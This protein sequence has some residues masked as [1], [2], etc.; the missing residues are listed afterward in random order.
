[1]TRI[2]LDIATG[3]PVNEP[4]AVIGTITKP[5]IRCGGYVDPRGDKRIREPGDETDDPEPDDTTYVR[6][7]AL[8]LQLQLVRDDP[9]CVATIAAA[10][11]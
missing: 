10:L 4:E 3:E 5:N 8:A 2:A 9:L 11:A 1:M 7:P 6:R